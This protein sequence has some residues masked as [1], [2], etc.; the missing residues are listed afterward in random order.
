ME[1]SAVRIFGKGILTMVI[2]AALGFVLFNGFGRHPY[3]PE[4]LEGVFLERAQ[5]QGIAGAGEETLLSLTYGNSV[6]FLLE[7][8]DGERACATYARSVFFDKYKEVQFYAGVTGVLAADEV[9]YRVSDGAAAYDMTV[10]F[11]QTPAI[12]PA[13]TVQPMLYIK[14]LGICCVAMGIFGSRIF[15]RKK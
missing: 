1:K 13:D 15:F 5:A 14:F 12:L 2:V 8:E 10:R 3:L 6:T 9:T 11:G 4:E 7:T